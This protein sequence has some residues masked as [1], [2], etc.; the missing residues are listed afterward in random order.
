[1]RLKILYANLKATYDRRERLLRSESGAA[2]EPLSA[3][4]NEKMEERNETR[5]AAI[6]P[7]RRK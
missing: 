6:A 2:K 5:E 3:G 7:F 4:I 1:L